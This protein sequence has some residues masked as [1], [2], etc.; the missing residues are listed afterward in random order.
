VGVMQSFSES[1]GV[2]GF[3]HVKSCSLDGRFVV[4]WM[5]Q[6]MLHGFKKKGACTLLTSRSSMIMGQPELML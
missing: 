1:D 5:R 3:P 2:V 6:V 4:I